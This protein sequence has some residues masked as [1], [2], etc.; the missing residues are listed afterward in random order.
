MIR[1]TTAQFNFKLP[2]KFSELVTAEVSFWQENNVGTVDAPLPIVKTLLSCAET[3]N[4]Y[5]LSV[6]LSPHETARFVVERKGYAQLIA[7]VADGTKFGNKEWQFSV[8]PMYEGTQIP[9]DDSDLDDWI[10]LDGGNI[11]EVV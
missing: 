7:E 1:G 6:T 3:D 9:D 10:I 11:T 4:P 5:E 8:Y 2:Y